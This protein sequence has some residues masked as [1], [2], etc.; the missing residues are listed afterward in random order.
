MDENN[1]DMD[2]NRDAL[3]VYLTC[4]DDKS[5]IVGFINQ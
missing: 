3:Y 4:K 2:E 1:N 5:K